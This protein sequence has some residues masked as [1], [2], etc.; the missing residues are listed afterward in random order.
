[1]SQ[2]ER[3]HY[4]RQRY[5]EIERLV[6]EVKPR[7]RPK[8]EDAS[9]EVGNA[10]FDMIIGCC[11]ILINYIKAD[12]SRADESFV[13]LRQWAISDRSEDNM[14]PTNSEYFP[15]IIRS[16]SETEFNLG[17]ERAAVVTQYG[18][19]TLL[20]AFNGNDVGV[21]PDNMPNAFITN[22]DPT[23]KGTDEEGNVMI[24]GVA[25]KPTS[26]DAMKAGVTASATDG[27]SYTESWVNRWSEAR[28]YTPFSLCSSYQTWLE[29]LVAQ[30]LTWEEAK[31]Y[32]IQHIL[33]GVL[34][35]A[36]E[37]ACRTSKANL[38]KGKEISAVGLLKAWISGSPIA[39]PA[40][41][42]EWRKPMTYKYVS[43]IDVGYPEV[44]DKG[45]AEWSREELS[46]AIGGEQVNETNMPFIERSN[47]SYPLQN[48]ALTTMGPLRMFLCFNA[49]LE[50]TGASHLKG[51]HTYY[52]GLLTFLGR[53]PGRVGRK[54]DKVVVKMARLLTTLMYVESPTSVM[55]EGNTQP[56]E[57][58]TELV[59]FYDEYA[60]RIL[61]TNADIK[62]HKDRM[63]I[64]KSIASEIPD[65]QEGLELI[66]SE[67]G[68]EDD[69]L[70][71]KHRVF[72]HGSNLLD[73]IT[74]LS[75]AGSVEGYVR[76]CLGSLPVSGYKSGAQRQLSEKLDT[77]AHDRGVDPFER[78]LAEEMFSTI[79]PPDY[80]TLFK[81]MRK[82]SNAKSGG[83]DRVR[84]KVSRGKILGDSTDT[85]E[86]GFSSN[87]KDMMAL[88]AG[89]MVTPDYMRI[90][91]TPKEPFP[92]GL[93][94]V[95]ARK[96]RYIYNLPLPQQ[97]V[98]Y[99]MYDAM[100]EYMA[101][102]E[103]YAL[104]QKIGIPVADAA[105]EINSSLMLMRSRNVVC[106]AHDASSLDQH[107]GVAHRRNLL[108]AA[109]QIL[110]H[111]QNESL[112][113]H[114]KATY[115]E[116]L[117]STLQCWDNS[118]YNV[119][120]PGAPSQL[121]NVDTQ[122]SGALT[123]AVDNT[124]VTMAML[125]MIAAKTD[126]TFMT[127][128]V[129]GDDCYVIQGSS[130]KDVIEVI[131]EQ[132]MLAGEAGQVLGTVSDST[133]GRV[134]HFLQKLYV[135]GQE[136][137]RRMAYDHE[138][139]VQ[140]ERLP[141]NVGEFLDKAR[142]MC[143]RGGNERLLNM[144]QL[145]TVINGSRATIFGRQARTTFKSM[146]CPGGM[147]NRLLVGYQSPNSELYL[148][149]NA[150]E[151]F[152]EKQSEIGVRSQLEQPIRIGERVLEDNEQQ[153]AVVVGG[154]EA[155][156]SLGSLKT[157]AS[158][159]LLES[160]R[161]LASGVITNKFKEHVS[162]IGYDKYNYVQSIERSAEMATG[163]VLRDKHLAPKFRE[164][165]LI[166]GGYIGKSLGEQPLSDK[167]QL[168]SMHAGFRIG[169]RVIN[170]SFS[171]QYILKLTSAENRTFKL[172]DVINGGEPITAFRE[173][174]HPYF[175]MPR[176]Y[177]QVLSLL[178]VHTSRE[179]LNVKSFLQKFSPA[180]FRNDLTA[181]EVIR[182]LKK[183][184]KP[185][186]MPFLKYV[187]FTDNEIDVIIS[188]ISS[189]YL[190]E[191]ITD[192]KE[193]ASTPDIIKS[194]SAHRIQQLMTYTSPEVV[195]LVEGDG[196]LRAL[197]QS[198]FVALLVD[199]MNIACSSPSPLGREHD[200]IRLPVVSI[201]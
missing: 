179:Q 154:I 101:F 180:H 16:P 63:S 191:H 201:N 138:K 113:Y 102:N 59:K 170:Y 44:K 99:P 132:E 186:V 79:A 159:K 73:V 182:A 39:I 45:L 51:M 40:W 23:T 42:Q 4:L 20:R 72:N 10:Q 34:Y 161:M 46:K 83:G 184:D 127:K 25:L 48:A 183:I 157:S 86:E 177:R 175:Y 77:S 158:S 37:W 1:L 193:Y 30:E 95:P 2:I 164:K 151:L 160:N 36:S 137:R 50:S 8:I 192:A 78:A 144:L 32:G 62:N 13:T 115:Y 119:Q 6:E 84:F 156:A 71:R 93:R 167:K 5:D 171:S 198:H 33:T 118:Y 197:V 173:F 107:I 66:F 169:E 94:S 189:I 64:A 56:F 124:L 188:D 67:Y 142:D 114:L 123:T 52:S 133:S 57:T 162:S 195:S 174:W 47:G 85:N 81:Y 91:A 90:C 112:D 111:I 105:K 97:I 166:A 76:S 147:L 187:G 143:I 24:K 117:K 80:K 172:L 122:P 139:P 17:T 61:A 75:H 74:H 96:L 134:V 11:N 128:Q 152:G 3:E 41:M 146:A 155:S 181:E 103:G 14:N 70:A 12:E 87:R 135:C 131:K 178:G 9:V 92:L 100:K 43:Q 136:V 108:S 185:Y 196:M 153:V 116:L 120:V 29:L 65:L 125:N 109:K 121:L 148:Q 149:L 28:R 27:I 88:T 145:M 199:E 49:A 165:A 110:E 60:L 176:A 53:N 26:L 140:S 19:D 98:L 194:C 200:Y 130:P 35:L 168:S 129:W 55:L 69:E 150:T 18:M 68:N 38:K 22:I 58:E 163:G 104:A 31:Q 7:V 21:D 126:T 15:T 141:G 54:A 89:M 82:L 190:Y 106:L